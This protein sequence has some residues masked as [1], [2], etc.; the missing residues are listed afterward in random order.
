MDGNQSSLEVFGVRGSKL[1][2]ESVGIVLQS[3]SHAIADELQDGRQRREE[4]GGE[5]ERDNR[6]RLPAG[7][8]ERGEERLVVEEERKGEKR[9][10]GLHERSGEQQQDMLAGPVTKLMSYR[11]RC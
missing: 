4:S 10:A 7:E 2:S 6:R 3:A 5:E 9:E 11:K 8:A 1:D